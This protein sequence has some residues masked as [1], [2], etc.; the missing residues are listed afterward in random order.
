MYHQVSPR[1]LRAF[2]RYTVLP[3]VFA[4]QMKWLA[5]AGYEPISL[6]QLVEHRCG[7]LELPARPV[8]ITFDDGFRELVDHAI[9]I[10]RAQGFTATFFLVAGLMGKNGRWLRQEIGA[11]IPLMGW[12]VARE[13]AATG[14]HCG[15]HTMS[16]PRLAGLPDS[17]CR[18]ELNDSRR[19]LEDR[20]GIEVS[21][22]AYPFGSFDD[23]VRDLAAEAGYRSACSTRRGLST[24]A[25]DLLS[26]HRI[27]VYGH[28]TI[29]TFICRLA[30]ARTP[31]EL[32]RE[33]LRGF[34]QRTE[35][36]TN[37]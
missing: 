19:L 3:E 8:V 27:S 24:A 4:A 9:P 31:R 30:T 20:L 7:R 16:H 26:L 22:L 17:A 18:S 11:E 33:K 14:F 32:L 34:R 35:E 25:D 36:V 28:D 2:A 15:A 10:L 13:L 5:Y 6:D 21:H 12:S 37:G 23:R 29:F 1:P